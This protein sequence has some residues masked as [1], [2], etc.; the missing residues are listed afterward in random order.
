MF[1]N[2]ACGEVAMRPLIVYP[3]RFQEKVRLSLVQFRVPQMW[4]I[5]KS[6]ARLLALMDS[7]ASRPNFWKGHSLVAIA[8]FHRGNGHSTTSS[9]KHVA[10]RTTNEPFHLDLGLL[11]NTIQV[12]D[13]LVRKGADRQENLGRL[14][15]DFLWTWHL[16]TSWDLLQW[17]HQKRECSMVRKML[18]Y[19][20]PASLSTFLKVAQTIS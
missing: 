3:L 12:H 10:V 16:A 6:S 19:S 7:I 5:V 4:E 14:V 1:M 13:F 20:S 17:T 2:V 18:K 15:V 11:D 9:R 8:G